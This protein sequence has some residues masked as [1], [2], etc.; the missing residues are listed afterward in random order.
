MA[1]ERTEEISAIEARIRK[2]ELREAAF[3][4]F[5]VVLVI[6]IISMGLVFGW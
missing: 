3:C 4:I 5:G 1:E 2:R 6:V